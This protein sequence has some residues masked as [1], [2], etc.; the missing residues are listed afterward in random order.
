MANVFLANIWGT[1]FLKYSGGA[2][3]RVHNLPRGGGYGDFEGGSS[4]FNIAIKGGG[5]SKIAWK[6]GRCLGGV[7]KKFPN[8]FI[9]I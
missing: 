4:F 7:T 3:G 1:L 6:Y 9:C 5:L 2:L 8:V